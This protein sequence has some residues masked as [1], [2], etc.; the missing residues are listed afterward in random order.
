MPSQ[1]CKKN[2]SK[3]KDRKIRYNRRN[4]KINQ[5]RKLLAQKQKQ[6]VVHEKNVISPWKNKLGKIFY[7]GLQYFNLIYKIQQY[8]MTTNEPVPPAE[9][10]YEEE[11]QQS[12]TDPDITISQNIH[13]ED[14]SI[15]DSTYDHKLDDEIS[16]S[17]EIS[18]ISMTESASES[19][20]SLSKQSIL[21]EDKSKI[22]KDNNSFIE[23]EEAVE[24]L[25]DTKEYQ[26][27][28]CNVEIN[29]E[30]EID[31]KSSNK[32]DEISEISKE[33]KKYQNNY[34]TEI[35]NDAE[36]HSGAFSIRQS[37]IKLLSQHPEYAN[38]SSTTNGIINNDNT[39]VLAEFNKNFDE[40]YDEDVKYKNIAP[41][42]RPQVLPE[43]IS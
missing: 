28:N 7:Y 5:R 2:K 11:F 41:I 10:L 33:R 24:D 34:V 30:G 32:N 43:E 42:A 38:S 23:N 25:N 35:N 20:E 3:A 13:C 16:F 31:N 36:N 21:D 22:E 1:F 17:T 18:E 9:N 37:L 40:F 27:N 12:S 4:K 6:V 29:N 39:D 15:N 14:S 26:E 19:L 8:I